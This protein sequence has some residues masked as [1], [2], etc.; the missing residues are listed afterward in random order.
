MAGFRKRIYGG[1][2]KAVSKRAKPSIS[3]ELLR[4]KRQV[5][6]SVNVGHLDYN[7]V[8]EAHT[9]GVFT[10]LSGIAQGTDAD[11][12]ISDKIQ[13]LGLEYKMSVTP[14]GSQSAN[15]NIEVYLYLDRSPNG[16][17]PTLT[18]FLQSATSLSYPKWENKDR[19]KILKKFYMVAPTYS[20]FN[21]NGGANV[22]TGYIKIGQQAQYTGSSNGI[23][24]IGTNAV[25]FLAVGDTANGAL[26][27]PFV[28]M[29]TRLTYTQ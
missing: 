9:S 26:T 5:A 18:D 4:L 1:P 2:G 7:V 25:G 3:T 16:A 11:D 12:R 13:L 19:F 15:Q 29:A 17:V 8:V 6:A 22:K 27:N 24:A 23:S 10:T 20:L 28:S 21:G 14:D